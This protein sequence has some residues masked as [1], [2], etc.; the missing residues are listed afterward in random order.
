MAAVKTGEDRILAV[1]SGSSSLKFG[2]YRPP[3]ADEDPAPV[4]TGGAIGIGHSNGR[5]QIKDVQGAVQVDKPYRLDSQGHALAEIL[6]TIDQTSQGRPSMI[7]HR[8]VHG[9]PHLR[10]HQQITESLVRTLEAAVHFAPLH[11]PAAVKLIRETTKLLPEV[12]Q[13]ACFDTAFH[14]TM[15]ETSR[16]YPLPEH[17]YEKGVERFGFHGISYESLLYRLGDDLPDRVV[18][19]HL[20][21]GASLVALFRGRSVD[22]SMGMTPTGG[23]PMATRPGDLDPGILLYLLRTEHLSA[24]QMESLLNHD[25]GLGAIAGGESD[26]RLLEECAAKGDPRARL[27]IE[28]FAQAV[29][30]QIGAYAAELGGLDRMIFTGGIG[31][32]NALMR[33]RICDGL[34]FLGLTSGDPARCAK[35]LVIPAEEELQIARITARLHVGTVL[36]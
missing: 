17:L 22:T 31:E 7:G 16:H 26:M 20:G 18:A 6:K 10:E 11:I 4:L 19:A 24:D 32:H 14:R 1:N 30:K 5:L 28:I 8:I 27:A 12:P 2:L 33:D 15:P 23:I 3:A 21:S 9:G 29:K 34:D 25:S 13:Y 35:V 36:R